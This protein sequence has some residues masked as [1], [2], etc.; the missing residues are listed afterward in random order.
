MIYKDENNR[1]MINPFYTCQDSLVEKMVFGERNYQLIE[2]YL[3]KKINDLLA[4][5]NY[6]Q[7]YKIIQQ[8]QKEGIFPKEQNFQEGK[9][10]LPIHK[11]I[12][13]LL[14]EF[15]SDFYFTQKNLR[16]LPSYQQ[17]TTPKIY[18]TMLLQS[19][20]GKQGILE[21]ALKEFLQKKL[22]LYESQRED[23]VALDDYPN[24]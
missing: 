22:T 17:V 13:V 6:E 2:K 4:K 23:I 14:S 5:M 21:K 19:G 15:Y 16:K 3:Y 9:N 10:N 12:K 20:I 7:L 8:L 11:M 18:M 1:L 24:L